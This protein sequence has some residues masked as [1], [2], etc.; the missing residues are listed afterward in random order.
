MLDFLAP[1]WRDAGLHCLVSLS[2][3][4]KGPRHYW[5]DEYSDYTP[6]L[7]RHTEP[8]VDFYWAP[9]TYTRTERKQ[10][11]VQSVSA[12]WLDV[13]TGLN[14]P[15]PSME[16]ALEALDRF[17]SDS[18]L[19]EPTHVVGSGY[20]LHVYWLL[21]TSL[22]PA[23]WEAHA[24]CLAAMCREYQFEVDPK[25]TADSASILRVPGTLNWKDVESPK[26][27]TLL[28][29]SA[30]TIA[31]GLMQGKLSPFKAQGLVPRSGKQMAKAAE[32][33]FSV[34]AIIR[35]PVSAH[36]IAERC[37]QMGHIR[38]TRG[39]VPEP[40]WYDALSVLRL[41]KESPAICHEWSSGHPE[42]SAAAT[43]QKI[44]QLA[45]KDIGAILCETFLRDSDDPSRCKMCPSRTKVRTPY[46][47]ARNIDKDAT[48]EIGVPTP[49][50]IDAQGCVIYQEGPD[51]PEERI[52]AHPLRIIARLDDGEQQS[53]LIEIDTPREG[54]QEIELPLS[55][56]YARTLYERLAARGILV[57][58]KHQELVRIFFITSAQRLQESEELRAVAHHMGWQD[59][60]GFLLGRDRIYA[61][62][63]KIGAVSG[64]VR[65]TAKALTVKG[66]LS[67]WLP[68]VHHYAA[69]PP[70][71]GFAFLAGVGAPLMR[72][73]GL[74]GV[75][76]SLTGLTGTGKSTVQRAVASAYG[77][78]AALL[79]QQTDTPKSLM[80]RMGQYHSLPVC[81]DEMTNI[82]PDELSDMVYQATQGKERARLLMRES[83]VVLAEP[84]HW[85]TMMIIS[86][87]HSVL[88]KLSAAKAD[89]RAEAM[90]V[91]EMQMKTYGDPDDMLLINQLIRAH[92]GHFGRQLVPLFIRSGKA[93]MEGVGTRVGQWDWRQEE[94]FW[95][96][97]ATIVMAMA[98][99][100]KGTG[101]ADFPQLALKDYILE[102]RR[103]L[104]TNVERIHR[105]STDQVLSAFFQA[106]GNDILHVTRNTT[107][108][109]A[110]P[111]SGKVV[112]R[113]EAFRN[114][115]YLD[116]RV[117]LQFINENRF[118]SMEAIWAS[119]TEKKG[120]PETTTYN[121]YKGLPLPSTPVEVIR[122]TTQKDDIYAVGGVAAPV[123]K[124]GEAFP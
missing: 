36:D 32:D 14:K 48:R 104:R 2:K 34:A 20:G 12:F 123:Q 44:A 63:V 91:W 124:V 96:G 47:L 80:H 42:Y 57:A 18:G 43:D 87:N 10:V 69:A 21:S 110:L 4:R 51:A 81:V 92:H 83:K 40:M 93:L 122:L 89:A 55:V 64:A 72:F 58:M 113:Y 38:D 116:R 102:R 23:V 27:V 5:S 53:I 19:P 3:N 1:F 54:T 15:Y 41:T 85:Q 30:S 78:P 99:L 68:V 60:G 97:A 61:H 8:G 77:D 28:R 109:L 31:P 76:V 95:Q 62:E 73:L 24:K 25:R 107:E 112:G 117:F 114:H 33:E 65:R 115:L 86:T 111:K 120:D 7:A 70:A 9:A 75:M 45:E 56:I 90:R 37:G 94:R 88:S 29:H 52:F 74:N 35:R 67:H 11:A 121:L 26:P 50:A 79:A 82:N 98:V 17:L 118:G 39:N 22:I 119:W 49:F 46:S 103:A 105:M 71:W 59:D 13:D 100:L 16:V 6:V 84:A 101:I 66:T 106:Y 108:G